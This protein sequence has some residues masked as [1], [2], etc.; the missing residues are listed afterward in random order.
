MDL[1]PTSR[2]MYLLLVTS[3]FSCKERTPVVTRAYYYW[4]N[5]TS[6]TEQERKFLRQHQVRKLYAKCLD[7]DWSDVNHAWPLTIN[8]VHEIGYGFKNYGDTVNATVVPVVFITNKTFQHIDSSEIPMLATHVLRK[9][10]PGFDS[11][12][13][14]IDRY[15]HSF[16]IPPEIQ[17]DCD[18]T[19]AT[20]DKYFYFLR[21]MRKQLGDRNVLMSATIRLHQFKYPQLTGVPPVNRG[22]LMVYNISRLTDYTPTNSIYD[23]EKA[24]PYFTRKK[25]YA[26]PLDIAL[27][28]YSWGLFYR[29]GKFMMIDNALTADSLR[30]CAFLQPSTGNFYK[31]TAD[32]TF[33]N[34]Y[35]R[36]GDEIK[37]E[38]IDD[39]TLLQAAKMAGKAINT[40]SFSVALFELSSLE[41]KNYQHEIIEQVYTDFGR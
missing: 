14:P 38:Q 15:Y 19:V 10:I 6:V 31:V 2:F 37:I 11:A 7:V 25:P 28:A 4:R 27:P 1:P 32:T 5:S 39:H 35:L 41:I 8:N 24:K 18:W 36:P 21:S 22:M 29:R 3:L 13:I 26:L 34:V 33:C 30:K 16:S 23:D 12:S 17:L 20:R 9:C 40:D